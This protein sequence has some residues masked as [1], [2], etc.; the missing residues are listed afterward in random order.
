M[1]VRLYDNSLLL[2]KQVIEK[3]DY[4]AHADWARLSEAIEW[5][6]DAYLALPVSCWTPFVIRLIAAHQTP[7]APREPS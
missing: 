5:A 1:G 4:Y 3:C 7:S 6:N 2:P